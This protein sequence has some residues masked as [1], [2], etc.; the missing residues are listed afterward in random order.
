MGKLKKSSDFQEISQ[1]IFV[2]FCNRDVNVPVSFIQKYLMRKLDLTS[3]TEVSRS[4]LDDYTINK[5]MFVNLERSFVLN[6]I[7]K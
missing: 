5:F 3:E 6:G 2:S 7:I 4:V 1:V